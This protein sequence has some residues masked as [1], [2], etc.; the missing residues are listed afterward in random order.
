MALRYGLRE[1][2]K[3]RPD[4]LCG[5]DIL[6]IFRLLMC[7]LSQGGHNVAEAV[8]EPLFQRSRVPRLIYERSRIFGKTRYARIKFLRHILMGQAKLST[9]GVVTQPYEFIPK[10]NHPE[11]Q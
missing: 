4:S 5:C 1:Q 3:R 6:L 7:V 8:M 2:T 10:G 11:A 9:V